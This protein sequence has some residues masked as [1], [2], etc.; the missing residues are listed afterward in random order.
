[1]SSNILFHEIENLAASQLLDYRSNNPGTC[2]SKLGFNINLT[3]AYNVQDAVTKLRVESGERVIG[4]K[5]GCT[6]P[7]TR[8][9]FGMDGPVRDGDE[10]IVCID[11]EPTVSCKIKTV[12]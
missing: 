4:Y 1:M 11:G 10:I 8:A 5:V 3:A 6:G 2:F 9:Q 12:R 7:G